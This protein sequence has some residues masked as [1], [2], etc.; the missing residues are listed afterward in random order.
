MEM[1]VK[2]RDVFA[3]L[4]TGYGK[5]LCFCCLPIVFDKL[6]GRGEEERLIIVVATPL[7]AIVK[8]QVGAF[9]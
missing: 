3:V 1:F 5:N 2:G 6:L 9:Y 8:D 7:T 4:L